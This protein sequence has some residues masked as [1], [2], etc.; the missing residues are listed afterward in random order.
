MRQNLRK[1]VLFAAALMSVCLP[2]AIAL[3][4]THYIA[5]R[6]PAMVLADVVPREITGWQE[7]KNFQLA[8]PDPTVREVLDATYSQTLTRGFVNSKGQVMMLTIAYGR[9]QN[10]EATAAH[11]PEFCYA[12]AGFH[13]IDLGV[14]HVN[15]QNETSLTL[16]HMLA[17]KPDRQEKISYWVT[18]DETATLPGFGR[19]LAQIRYGL[20]GQIADGMLVRLSSPNVTGDEAFEM[21]A[22]FLRHLY[23]H[24]APTFKARIFGV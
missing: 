13:M 3:K 18:L 2:A 8:V 7:L 5:D 12:G 24:I 19:K 6:K 23:A 10:S 4:P 1:S 11:R 15:L 17:T 22:D 20:G 14:K 9:D 21:H 16:R